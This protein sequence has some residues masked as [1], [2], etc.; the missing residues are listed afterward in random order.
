MFVGSKNGK[1]CGLV[2][3]FGEVSSLLTVT[4][5]EDLYKHATSEPYNVLVTD[6]HSKAERDKRF[7]KEF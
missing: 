5:F 1:T 7:K 6:N 3:I 2:K 4:Q